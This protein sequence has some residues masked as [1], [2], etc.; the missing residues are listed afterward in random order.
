MVGVSASSDSE[1]MKPRQ[2]P[3]PPIDGA[4]TTSFTLSRQ[5]EKIEAVEVG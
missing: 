3:R 5:R 2:T 4:D 1:G